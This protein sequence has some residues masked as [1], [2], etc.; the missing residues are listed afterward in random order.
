[1]LARHPFEVIELVEGLDWLMP[2]YNVVVV[3]VVGFQADVERAIERIV[4][5]SLILRGYNSLSNTKSEVAQNPS[6][7]QGFVM[8]VAWKGLVGSASDTAA[9]STYIWPPT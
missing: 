9:A 6:S 1:M 8:G 4:I 3:V 5:S 2:Y 7:F